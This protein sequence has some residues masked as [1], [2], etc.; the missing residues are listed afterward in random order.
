MLS[1][2]VL[3][4]GPEA[5]NHHGAPVDTPAP[6]LSRH[7]KYDKL[8]L[9]EPS[10]HVKYNRLSVPEPSRHV[11]YDKLSLP[12]PSRHVKSADPRSEC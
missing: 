1:T 9:L 5:A 2:E 11:K 10:R 7:L 12:E 6:G 3:S 4:R 8:S